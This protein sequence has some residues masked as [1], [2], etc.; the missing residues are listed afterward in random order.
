VVATKG[1]DASFLRPSTPAKAGIQL[2]D[3]VC[4]PFDTS[5]NWTPAFA[6]V[7]GRRNE[8][9]SPLVAT[10]CALA[11]GETDQS[12]PSACMYTSRIDCSS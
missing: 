7:E 9:S 10:T 11:E 5:H 3:D 1:D 8:A 2:G 6:G 12:I 4:T